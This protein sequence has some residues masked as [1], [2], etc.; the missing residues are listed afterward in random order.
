MKGLY[1]KEREEIN[2]FAPE[3]IDLP[4]SEFDKIIEEIDGRYFLR[5]KSPVNIRMSGKK[6]QVYTDAQKIAYYKKKAKTANTKKSAYR[7]TGY[8]KRGGGRGSNRSVVITGMGDY[9]MN[10]EDALG[11]R[12]GGYLGS[13]AGEYLGGMAHNLFSSVTGF[14]DYKV[15]ENVFMA[16]RLPEVVNI[17]QGG[18]TVIR[19]QE[20]LGDVI[21]SATPNTFNLQNYLLNPANSRTFPFLSGVA[22]QYE[23]YQME[24]LLFEF[25]STSA[26]AL[27]STNTAL[28][29][30]IL[31]TE[32]NSTNPNFSSKA[33]MLNHEFSNSIKPSESV[34]HMVECAPSQTT[35]T[36]LYTLEGDVPTGADPRLYYL[37]NFQI[38]TVGFQGSSVNIGELHVTYQVRLMKPQL[39]SALG[40]S[41]NFAVISNTAYTNASPFG[42]GTQTVA[43]DN[44]GVSVSGN[45]ITFPGSSVPISYRI[46]LYW[47]GV[48]APY[49]QAGLSTINCSSIL[50]NYGA[51]N[52]GTST[53]QVLQT[54]AI[55]PATNGLSS[56][57]TINGSGAYPTSGSNMVIR[58]M[59]VPAGSTL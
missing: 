48:T 12:Y 24:G 40:E 10:P 18:G 11:R 8:V 26:D 1:G 13:K 28:G 16:G 45:S 20:Y 27:N 6:S 17:P 15:Q 25:R 59:Q 32:Y 57:V 21:T 46:E 19:F 55:S 38:A 37:G 41:I 4:E 47:S 2:P 9:R 53:L 43:S 33:Q 44:I 34:M 7:K 22:Q 51:P 5:K 30:V 58:I 54:L 23:Q 50:S 31:S 39:S 36:N 14:G 35:V 56:Q 42:T 49:T 3:W 29:S 52:P